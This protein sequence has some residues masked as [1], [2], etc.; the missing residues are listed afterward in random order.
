MAG[1]VDTSPRTEVEMQ[2]RQE[3]S[4][5]ETTRATRRIVRVDEET[6][7]DEVLAAEVPVLVEFGAKWCGP[8]RAL[9]PVLHRLADE[10]EGRWK[11]A[12]I[13]IDESPALAAKYSVRGAPTMMVFTAGVERARH[14]GLTRHETL[15]ALIERASA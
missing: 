15:T 12:T 14:L 1:L 3:T 2:S 6:F 13:D 5:Q 10:A 4:G 7:A 11:I 9:E 8:C